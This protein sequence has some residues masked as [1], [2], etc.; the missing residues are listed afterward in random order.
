MVV[1]VVRVNAIATLVK[2]DASSSRCR[3]GQGV[4]HRGGRGVFHRG[5]RGGRGQGG[6]DSGGDSDRHRGWAVDP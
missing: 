3:G 5:G 6:G 4:F 1:V 2:A